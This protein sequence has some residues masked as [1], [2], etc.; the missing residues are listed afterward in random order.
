[1][2]ENEDFKGKLVGQ[3]YTRQ[4]GSSSRLPDYF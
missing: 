4:L 3:Q 1:M 2:G